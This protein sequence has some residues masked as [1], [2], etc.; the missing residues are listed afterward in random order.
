M[1]RALRSHGPKERN[2]VSDSLIRIEVI[3]YFHRNPGLE[4]T[5]MEL[6]DSIGRDRARVEDQ[7]KKLVQLNI[8]DRRTLGSEPRYRYIPPH[9][10][11]R[12][13]ERA[14]RSEASGGGRVLEAKPSPIIEAQG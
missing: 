6:A 8:L 11:S 1:A 9:Y 14:P 13:R 7:M 2:G 3:T 12:K 4:G 5:S 10:V